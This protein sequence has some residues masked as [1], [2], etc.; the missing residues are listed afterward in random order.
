MAAVTVEQMRALEASSMA[1]GWTEEGLMDLAGARL[2]KAIANFFPRP[3]FIV[4]YLGKGHNAGDACVALR[5]LRENFNWQVAIRASHPPSECAPLTRK[6][7]GLLEIDSLDNP[8]DWR[9]ATRPLVL[10]DALL[11]IGGKGDLRDPLLPMAEEMA[12][13]RQHAGAMVA[14]LDLPSGVDADSGMVF[15]GAV[16]A[17]VTFQIG[18][19]KIGLLRTKAANNCGALA[20]VPVEI[21][22]DIAADTDRLIAPQSMDFGKTR[23]P[24]DFHKGLAGRVSIIAGSESYPGAAVLCAIGALRAGAGLV[25]LHIPAS[26]ASRVSSQ[27]PP[28]IIIRTFD[29]PEEALDFRCDARVIGCGL[30]ENAGEEYLP[31]ILAHEVRTILDADALNLVAKKQLLSEL[32]ENHVLTPHPGEFARLAPDLALLDR[33]TAARQFTRRFSGTLLLKGCRS[34]IAK[35][36]EPLWFN[37]TGHPGMATAGQ[38]DLLAGTIGALLARGETPMH[39]AALAA[40]ICGRAAERL[41]HLGTE[42]EESLATGS[43]PS[44]FGAAFEDWRC[45]LR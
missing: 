42:S 17:D 25:T 28:E 11:G 30:G 40:W 26:I 35:M 8:P 31:L 39:A 37:A 38:G 34:I 24:F 7:L 9:D 10:L 27:C 13:L 19:E 14:A 23:R 29:R 2:A 16:M 18:A 20:I 41:I 21:L 43:L 3:G 33:E 45:G 5:H 1:R 22:T 44:Q 36:N 12:W 32:R 15:A 4:A 6:K